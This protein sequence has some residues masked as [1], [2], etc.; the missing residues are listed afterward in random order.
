RRCSRS[1]YATC[2][3]RIMSVTWGITDVTGGQP[4]SQFGRFID[5]WNAVKLGLL[6]P[7]RLRG[8]S[9]RV[10]QQR[11]VE[12]STGYLDF[13]QLDAEVVNI[14][15]DLVAFGVDTAYVTFGFGCER[16]KAVQWQEIPV[17]VRSLVQFVADGEAD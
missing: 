12:L 9:D 1:S 4:F 11:M 16:G 14:A 6:W 10:C 13:E 15:D 7:R 3:M 2:T 5:G 8:S 17:P